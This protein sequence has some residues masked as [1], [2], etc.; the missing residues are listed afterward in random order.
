MVY[1][2]QK[3]DGYRLLSRAVE[4]AVRRSIGRGVGCFL[5]VSLAV[6][7]LSLVTWSVAD[8]SLTHFTREP[9]GNLLGYPGAVVSDLMLQT[10]GL[11][12][13][14]LLFAPMFWGLELTLSGN[15]AAIR[16]KLLSYSA[17]VLA[18]AGFLSALPTMELWQLN[19][20]YGGLVGD[21]VLA[22]AS[23]GIGNL[24]ADFANLIAG[25]VLLVVG[26]LFTCFSI[27]IDA[28]TLKTRARDLFSQRAVRRSRRAR[29]RH[30]EFPEDSDPGRDR[31]TW[32][33]QSRYRGSQRHWQEPHSEP[34]LSGHSY[35][36]TPKNEF[37][38]PSGNGPIGEAASWQDLRSAQLQPDGEA[39]QDEPFHVRPNLRQTSTAHRER[40]PGDLG[41]AP[42]SPEPSQVASSALR[43][44]EDRQR[45]TAGRLDHSPSFVLAFDAEELAQRHRGDDFD[46]VTDFDS[47]AIAKRF[48]PAGQDEKPTGVFAGM[49]RGA[50]RRRS[51][52]AQDSDSIAPSRP[53]TLERI[54]P[55][56]GPKTAAHQSSPIRE[57][58]SEILARA[59]TE[60]ADP[61]EAEHLVEESS[62][63]APP[64][65]PVATA[66][67]E[68]SDNPGAE[69]PAARP[70]EVASVVPLKPVKQHVPSK[71]PLRTVS[72]YQR[73]SLNLLTGAGP[74]RPGPEMTQAVLRGTARLLQDVLERF[75][76][77]GE[78][79]EIRPGP[80]VTV[81]HVT[82]QAGTSAARVV[83]LADDIARAMSA[84]SARV[85]SIPGTNAIGIELPNVH[86]EAMRLRE[87]LSSESYRSF[88]GH[89][90]IV[91]GRALGGQPIVGDLAGL[92]NIL[93]AG[94]HSSGKSTVLKSMLLSLVYRHG[95]DDCRFILIDPKLL[96]F[97]AFNRT[98]HLMCPVICDQD[99]AV[100]ALRWIV[101]EMDE[102]AKRMSKMSARTIDVF[103]NRVRHARKR[104]EMM[105][106]RVQTGF[107]RK[108]GKPIY[109]HEQMEYD[110]LPN[111]VIAIDELADLMD[112]AAAQVED[113][114]S[115][116]A[117]KGP[118]VGVFLVAGT[119][120]TTSL[121]VTDRLKAAFKSV[122]AFKLRS[123]I[124]SRRLV[125]DQGAEQLLDY[126]DMVLAS[127]GLQGARIHTVLTSDDDV[128]AVAGSLR[129]SGRPRYSPS[130]M[131]A[132]EEAADY[133]EDEQLMA[134]SIRQE[135]ER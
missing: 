126:G 21:G 32:Q 41:D 20:G 27:G 42:R 127:N 112:G 122:I 22:V 110:V 63:E 34:D 66:P 109:E 17:S 125:G 70:P 19:H 128:A 131:S 13:A 54:T 95:P 59:E 38:E 86:R 84:A 46:S 87:L 111:I 76:I 98:P 16:W 123:K 130:L 115:R 60:H 15:I 33:P 116:I 29:A 106:R 37:S 101:T 48:A 78:I 75:G 68:Q 67:L 64:K 120:T 69:E 135:P 44:G 31:E 90:P 39:R 133:P 99:K 28:E 23:W 92:A 61:L 56:A 81:F 119:K 5:L 117:E 65:E 55:E 62:S 2:Y 88:G 82:V 72:G 36:P 25:L 47:K 53:V 80:V 24:V 11:A 10:L 79:T 96:E 97:D 114:I 105:A 40:K 1:E 12:A 93:I 118:A 52:R 121:C 74:Q 26:S 71:M 124:D 89:L 107:D 108:T 102:R 58:F 57:S 91:L 30:D 51:E 83:G 100:A 113:A 132:I 50:V 6:L 9:A 49:L 103:N 73:P 18:L 94:T 85:A 4:D 129:E 35:R 104:G 134:A 14:V 43:A 45:S 8:P 7:W 77:H 3:E